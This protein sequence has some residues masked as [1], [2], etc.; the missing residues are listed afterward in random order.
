MLGVICGATVRLPAF[1]I[2][3]LGGAVIA[4][5]SIGFRNDGN[6]IWSAVVAAVVLQ[7]GYALGI[8]GRA[9][10]RSWRQAPGGSAERTSESRVPV[11]TE[12]KQR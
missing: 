7:A 11:P 12:P 3:L 2:I 6:P 10:M 8:I 1:I 4:A 9:V 5:L